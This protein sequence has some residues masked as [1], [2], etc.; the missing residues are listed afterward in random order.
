MKLAAEACGNLYI[1]RV[2]LTAVPKLEQGHKLSDVLTTGALRNELFL[3]LLQTGEQ[4]GNIDAMLYKAADH[5]EDETQLLIKRFTVVIVPVGVI[6][7]GIAV[8]LQMV[9]FYSGYFTGVMNITP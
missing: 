3:R 5:Y 7:A 1:T 2:L 4:T 8:V 6:I 9:Q